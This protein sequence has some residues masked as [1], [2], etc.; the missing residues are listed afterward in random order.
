M[1]GSGYHVPVMVPETLEF[2]ITDPSGVY[3]DATLGGGGHSEAILGR[4]SG[5]GRLVG[6]DRDA[7]ALAHAGGRLE[8][9]GA[10]AV[11]VRGDFASL[12]RC[13]GR[14]AGRP[15]HGVLFDLGVS[16]RQIDAAERGFSHQQDGPLDMRM[17]RDSGVTAAELLAR[18]GEKEL[19]D[20]IFRYGEERNARRIAAAI[21]R[22]RG[23]GPIRT[24]GELAEAVRSAAPARWQVKTLSRVFQALRLQVNEEPA[25]LEAG[26]AQA[27]AL[28]KPGGRLVVI[29]YH[30]IEDRT[31]KRFFRGPTAAQGPRLPLP[32]PER[33]AA[34][35]LLTR[36]VV[37]PGPEE[38][39]ANPRARS[40]KLR[41][42]EKP[43]GETPA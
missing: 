24:T 13:A 26:L 16:S 12:G 7:E 34:F 11:L 22:R 32:E 27:A 30:S 33:P 4:L 37:T 8:R 19:A 25:Q 35:R 36:G 9:F 42:A 23:R 2:L 21:V 15:V 1:N 31:V 43:Q 10:R 5:A 3:V 41:A 18:T 14:A 6:L 39:A 28:L 29:S 17:D 38:I 20:L 40:A